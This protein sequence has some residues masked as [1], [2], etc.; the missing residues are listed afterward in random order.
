MRFLLPAAVVVILDQVTKQIF[1]RI[2]EN[3]DV[4]DGVLRITLVRNAGAAF[5][6]F[7]GGRVLFIIT[8]VVAIIFITIIGMR[9]ERADRVRQVLLGIILGGA[10]GNLIDRVYAGAVIDFIDMGLGSRRWPVYN[11]ADIAV[12][13]GA[14]LL[15]L[16]LVRRPSDSAAVLSS[17]TGD[18][19][20]DQ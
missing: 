13:V 20:P 9:L 2:G 8:S 14:T 18:P 12:S 7:Q 15:L 19:N 16:Y 10:V 11:V 5:G 6:L 3:F 17:P 4:I 1:W